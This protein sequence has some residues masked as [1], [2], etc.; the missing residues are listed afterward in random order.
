M[1]GKINFLGLALALLIVFVSGVCAAAEESTFDSVNC[2]YFSGTI[3]AEV[4]FGALTQDG[5]LILA[6]YDTDNCPVFV[7]SVPVQKDKLS[8]DFKFITDNFQSDYTVKVFCWKS[9]NSLCPLTAAFTADVQKIAIDGGNAT[10]DESV[11]YESLKT[12]KTGE[13]IISDSEVVLGNGWQ[14][15][16][17]GYLHLRG[18]AAPLEFN[19]NAADGDLYWLTFTHNLNTI[20]MQEF[21]ISVACGDSDYLDIY[22]MTPNA[23]IILKCSGNNGTLKIK[24]SSAATPLITNISCRKIS[25]DGAYEEDIYTY[26]TYSDD[27][28]EKNQSGFW[29]V[30]FGKNALGENISG[31]RDIAIGKNSLGALESGNRNIAIGTYALPVMKNGDRNIVIGADSAFKLES[32]NDCIS[33][34]KATMSNGAS[35]TEDIAIGQQALYGVSGGNTSN[36]IGIGTYAGYKSTGKINVFIGRAAGYNAQNTTHNVFVGTEAGKS[37]TTGW[38]NTAIGANSFKTSPNLSKSV[39]IGYDAQPTKSN[40]V[41]LGGDNITETVIKGDL[42]VR[43][44]DGVYRQIVFNDDGSIGWTAADN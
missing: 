11:K 38:A 27:A 9:D 34:G 13:N 39:A 32:A 12:I 18:Y 37:V 42:I 6:I 43:G 21:D 2:E 5:T 24:A 1:K 8:Y 3:N 14:E 26:N 35:R 44:S 33:I 10:T 4:D 17:G 29:N 31:S 15:K 16:D 22:N 20:T 25:D 36:N 19:I 40:Q 30:A 41:M 28:L 23:S 7:S